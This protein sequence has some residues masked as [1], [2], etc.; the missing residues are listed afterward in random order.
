MRKYLL[1]VF[2]WL[3]LT[4]SGLTQCDSMTLSEAGSLLNRDTFYNLREQALRHMDSCLWSMAKKGETIPKNIPELFELHAPDSSFT[5]YSYR[6]RVHSALFSYR[7]IL[8]KQDNTYLLK[9][10]SVNKDD[11]N[12]NMRYSQDNWYGAIYFNLIDKKISGKNYYFLF[13]YRDLDAR[14]N[15]KLI[16]VLWFD[17][18]GEPQ[19]GASHFDLPNFENALRFY[20]NYGE[21][22]AAKL[23]YDPYKNLILKDHL[24]VSVVNGIPVLLPDG[25]YEALEWKKKKWRYIE[26]VYDEVL[27][28]APRPVPLKRDK[29]DLFGN[30]IK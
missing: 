26:K 9:K 30:D 11:L 3:A 13:G 10:D 28:E 7:A 17:D 29:K 16:D 15:Q 22:G 4:G 23:N 20:F 5:L 2:L 6:F 21:M 8:K 25:S 12:K 1:S 18:N 27:E 19:L 24:I 14:E